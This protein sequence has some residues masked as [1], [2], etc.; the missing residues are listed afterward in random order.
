[1]QDEKEEEIWYVVSESS[2]LLIRFVYF[3]ARYPARGE[4]ML[5]LREIDVR[6]YRQELA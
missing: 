2:I 6:C 3:P 4:Q 1:M 5:E